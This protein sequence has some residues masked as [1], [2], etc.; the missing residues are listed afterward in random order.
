MNPSDSKKLE[1]IEEQFG[2]LGYLYGEQDEWLISKIKE[3]EREIA[4][5]TFQV[6]G[7]AVE[8][9][10][11]KQ[12]AEKAE[13]DLAESIAL[14][15]GHTERLK[16]RVKELEANRSPVT[17]LADTLKARAKKELEAEKEK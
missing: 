6:K 17:V 8:R 16:T 15:D 10:S 9:T 13:Y 3:Q 1:E 12:R 2:R 11:A 7:L 5:L 14:A 4:R